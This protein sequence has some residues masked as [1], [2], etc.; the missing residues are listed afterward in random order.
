MVRRY[1]VSL[2]LLVLSLI[3]YGTSLFN[4]GYY[5]QGDNPRAWAPAFGLLLVGWIGVLDGVIAWIANPLLLVGWVMLGC[6]LKYAAVI[7]A[8]AAIF[9]I[10]SLQL[11]ETI[12]IDE[13]GGRSP[14]TG[15]GAGY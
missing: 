10:G 4:D 15:Y 9:C 3:A 14:I 1:P 11:C 6:R 8:V 12:L 2:P 5:I 13:S 7:F